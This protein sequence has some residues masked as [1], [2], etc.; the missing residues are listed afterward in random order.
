MRWCLVWTQAGGVKV[1]GRVWIPSVVI[2]LMSSNYRTV[3]R[4]FNILMLPV[5]GQLFSFNVIFYTGY[6][7]SNISHSLTLRGLASMSWPAYSERKN[8]SLWFQWA[9]VQITGTTPGPKH[10]RIKLAQGSLVS[11]LPAAVTRKPVPDHVTIRWLHNLMHS[12][13]HFMERKRCCVM[14]VPGLQD[15]PGDMVLWVPW[16]EANWV[17]GWSLEGHFPGKCQS[18]C[19]TF[20][21]TEFLCVKRLKIQ[22]EVVTTAELILP[23]LTQFFAKYQCGWYALTIKIALHLVG[24]VEKAPEEEVLLTLSSSG[25]FSFLFSLGTPIL[26][27]LYLY[28]GHLFPRSF[29]SI[30]H[31]SV[32]LLQGLFQP[33]VHPKK[34]KIVHGVLQF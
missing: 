25:Y 14:I 13:E 5:S 34:K 31:L 10:L 19:W 17:P 29:G 22:G 16:L 2:A 6:C 23:W 18:S 30:S 1:P 4:N 27:R 7:D 15:F 3:L 11:L 28:T 20:Y 32:Y 12:H 24:S 8:K 21:E 33:L 9:G 26:H